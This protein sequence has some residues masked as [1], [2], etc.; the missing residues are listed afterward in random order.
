MPINRSNKTSAINGKSLSVAALKKFLKEIEPIEQPDVLLAGD[1]KFGT[2]DDFLFERSKPDKNGVYSNV[3]LIKNSFNSI[4]DLIVAIKEQPSL[5]SFP[6]VATI[7][8]R[9]VND[10]YHYILIRKLNINKDNIDKYLLL[11]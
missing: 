2:I 8:Y 1:T 10:N 4:K 5:F 3:K 7:A 11:I 9:P 6:P